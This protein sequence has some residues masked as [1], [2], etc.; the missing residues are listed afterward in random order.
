MSATPRWPAGRD[1]SRF[2]AC[3]GLCVV[4]VLVKLP[5]GVAQENPGEPGPKASRLLTQLETKDPY[6][7][8]FAFLELEAL[9]EPAT[10]PMI[11]RYLDNRDPDTRA[12]SI[13]ALAAIEGP[14]AVPTLLERLK[15]E[16]HPRVRVAAVLALEPLQDPAILPAFIAKLRDRNKEVRMALVDAV[17]RVDS[18]EARAAIRLRW[19][20]ERDR[21]VR[22]VLEDAMKRVAEHG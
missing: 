19:R 11:R 2:L 9:R 8:Q 15:R 6:T 17:S 22:R 18:Q 3:A 21:D 1:R 12:F 7:R 20:R 16:R 14:A 4:G 13:R 10:A 5:A